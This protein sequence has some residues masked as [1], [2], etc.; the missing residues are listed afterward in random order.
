MSWE[1]AISAIYGYSTISHRNDRPIDFSNWNEALP[2]RLQTHPLSNA[3]AA[4]ACG[5]CRLSR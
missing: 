1:A 5:Y 4:S 3:N 2:D